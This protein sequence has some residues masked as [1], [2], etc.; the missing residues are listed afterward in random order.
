MSQEMIDI[1]DPT[2][3]DPQLAALVEKATATFQLEIMSALA[4]EAPA[5]K[6]AALDIAQG[7]LSSRVHR[8]TTDYY[9]RLS[10]EHRR[11]LA[12]RLVSH[13]ET[14][15]IIGKSKLASP[16][17]IKANRGVLHQLNL[18]SEYAFL[19]DQRKID[20]LIK[21]N[22]MMP[23]D[24]KLAGT[25]LAGRIPDR[26]IPGRVAA[27]AS[28]PIKTGSLQFRVHQV[29]CLD[30]SDWEWGSDEISMG[31]VTTDSKEKVDKI[32]EFKVKDD[33]DTN[34]SKTYSPPNVLKTFALSGSDYPKVHTVAL[35]LAEKDSG[36]FADFI[37]QL[38]EAVKDHIDEIMTAVGAAAGAAI[39]AAV[40]GSIGVIGGPLGSLIGVAAG[41][42]IGAL[43]GWIANTLKDEL[44]APKLA[45]LGIPEPGSLF[46]SSATS[47]TQQ[48]N[49]YE[50]GAHYRV[51]YSWHVEW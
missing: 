45:V 23:R 24:L 21:A 38:Y 36:G 30:M 3:R 51:K 8:A 17:S 1:S 16:L 27:S 11:V 29:T 44:F 46:G 2:A 22:V 33:F 4:R 12:T 13:D 15:R 20:S 5:H 43:V 37:Q 25:P 34:E 18:K 35:T 41:M 10:P 6:L 50:H 47:A 32:K 31:G 7:S 26:L 14:Q 40:G 42:I 19:G 28:A 9:K 48:L 39:G 49:Y